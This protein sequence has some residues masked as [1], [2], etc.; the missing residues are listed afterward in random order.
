MEATEFSIYINSLKNRME[1]MIINGGFAKT[2]TDFVNTSNH[3]GMK[4]DE[5]FIETVEY[6]TNQGIITKADKYDIEKEREA[7]EKA[8]N[9]FRMKAEKSTNKKAKAAKKKREQAKEP[10]KDDDNDLPDNPFYKNIL[11]FF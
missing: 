2:I 7:F 6:L 3:R 5:V 8:D 1:A 9:D 11:D 10:G 4:Y